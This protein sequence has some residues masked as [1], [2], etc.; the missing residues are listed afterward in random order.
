MGWLLLKDILLFL[1]W[2]YLNSRKE[3][4]VA[5]TPE[6]TTLKLVFEEGT[7][8]HGLTVRIR[9][10]TVGEWHEMLSKSGVSTSGPETVQINNEV[11][12]MFLKH[13]VSW[14]LEIPAGTPVPFTMEGWNKLENSHA[15]L[16][17]AA[18]QVSMLG[19]PKNSK[20]SSVDGN[21]SVESELDLESLSAS[22][23]NWNSPSSLS[24]SVTDSVS[25]RWPE[26]SWTSRPPS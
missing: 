6:K 9:P 5:F 22:L 13:L 3:A 17:I 15:N 23:P 20:T 18:W 1:L 10:C 12:E 8:L 4:A 19:I 2:L 16:L 21:N 11:A 7:P 24:G 14:D 25:S 26:G